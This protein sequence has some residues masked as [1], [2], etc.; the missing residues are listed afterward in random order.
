MEKL[1]KTIESLL[2]E[3]ERIIVFV[4]GLGGA[5][6]TTFAN[7]LVE[8]DVN[9]IALHSDW[10]LK[11]PTL[12]RRKRIQNAIESG[13]ENSIEIEE[14]PKNWY[15]WESMK[16]DILLLQEK[17]RV[18]VHDAWNQNTGLKN[19]KVPLEFFHKGVIICDGIYL[20]HP[21]IVDIADFT[22]LLDVPFEVCR[23]RS[24]KR[25]EHRNSSEYLALK[26][27]LTEKYD[28]PYF[29]KYRNNANLIMG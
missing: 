1:E 14:N 19:L 7:N 18:D 24:D 9:S 20:L 12:E 16:E 4:C 22:V 28:V 11:Y 8:Q 3:K 5:G 10:W 15:D 2:Q 26:A 13:D 23:K 27:H 6:K 29:E 17:G 21:E 25:D